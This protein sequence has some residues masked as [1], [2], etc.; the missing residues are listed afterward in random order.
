MCLSSEHVQVKIILRIRVKLSVNPL[1][2]V[3]PKTS[4]SSEDDV[5]YG[6]TGISV[7]PRRETGRNIQVGNRRTDRWETLEKKGWFFFRQAALP[8]TKPRS[9]RKSKTGAVCCF[10]PQVVGRWKI[11]RA[12]CFSIAKFG[13]AEVSAPLGRNGS[14]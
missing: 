12:I 10:F 2:A 11:R 14:S 8:G 4:I 5:M 3:L 13:L 6:L 9:S 7:C 1:R